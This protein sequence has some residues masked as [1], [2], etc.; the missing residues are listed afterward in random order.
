M[1][2]IELT[3]EAFFFAAMRVISLAKFGLAGIVIPSGLTGSRRW[4]RKKALF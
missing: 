4:V 1:S 2:R 3:S